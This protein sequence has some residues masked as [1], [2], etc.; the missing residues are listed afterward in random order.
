MA[1]WSTQSPRIVV[2]TEHFKYKDFVPILLVSCL[3]HLD[4]EYVFD[5]CSEITAPERGGGGEVGNSVNF[6]FLDRQNKKHEN[7]EHQ[8]GNNQFLIADL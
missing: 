1:Q 5:P 6:I 3:I 7:H 4:A 8:Y 2:Q